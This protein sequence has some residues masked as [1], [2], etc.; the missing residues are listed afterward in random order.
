[1]A[2]VAKSATAQTTVS[3]SDYLSAMWG[4][5]LQDQKGFYA[6]PA[7][8]FQTS[9]LS[10]PGCTTFAKWYDAKYNGLPEPVLSY[11]NCASNLTKPLRDYLPDEYPGN[12]YPGFQYCCGPC[13][14]QIDEIRVLY[15]P[16][17]SP[18]L[19]SNESLQTAVKNPNVTSTITSSSQKNHI[20]AGSLQT[21]AYS[22]AIVDG[23]TL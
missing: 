23:H 10:D 19:C 12:S 13:A 7:R 14:V 15:F 1:M 17:Q 4:W 5:G 9:F 3:C 18:I 21:D 2:Q 20:R 11:S 22:I 6:P 8:P 16:D